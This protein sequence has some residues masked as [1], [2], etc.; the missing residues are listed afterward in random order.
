[1]KKGLRELSYIVWNMFG[2]MPHD[3]TISHTD[4]YFWDGQRVALKCPTK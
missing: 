4:V 3:I 1:M 2:C